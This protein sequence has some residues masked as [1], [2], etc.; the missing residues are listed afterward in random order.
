LWI[1][2]KYVLI[3]NLSVMKIED[4]RRNIDLCIYKLK[5][6]LTKVSYIRWRYCKDSEVKLMVNNNSSKIELILFDG[7]RIT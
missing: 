3:K 7:Y 4:N 5:D 6:D 2:I 1:V